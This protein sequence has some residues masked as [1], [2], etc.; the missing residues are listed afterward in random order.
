MRRL[1]AWHYLTNIARCSRHMSLLLRYHHLHAYFPQTKR[2]WKK[3]EWALPR[4]T[5]ILSQL[6]I[7]PDPLL[8]DLSK[9]ESEAL[10][11]STPIMMI[12]W[13]EYWRVRYI[14]HFRCRS[15]LETT[16]LFWR[17]HHEGRRRRSHVH[18]S[19]VIQVQI[20]RSCTCKI[21]V[22]MMSWL[23][24]RIILHSI[25]FRYRRVMATLLLLTFTWKMLSL[26][27][28]FSR[29][30]LSV[31]VINNPGHW[32]PSAL[33][34]RHSS[35]LH[36]FQL[37]THHWHFFS[38]RTVA[39]PTHSIFWLS[40]YADSRICGSFFKQS[41]L[42]LEELSDLVEVPEQQSQ[43]Q[44]KHDDISKQ[45][46]RNKVKHTHPACSTVAII[47]HLIPVISHQHLKNSHT[48]PQNS[49]KIS[50]R[51]VRSIWVIVTALR[52]ETQLTCEEL[53]S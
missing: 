25:Q 6:F 37:F 10:L 9:F 32:D 24:L 16:L 33:K 43:E 41:L 11:R 22:S 5:L 7:L 21:Q 38:S 19:S 2:F 45:H 30:Y 20:L 50:T 35:S 1:L 34:I 12:A 28:C 31:L 36:L 44:I 14:F 47:H 18:T 4:R 51:Q 8:S 53:H 48:R 3:K 40:R 13:S 39:N 23:W 26:G 49:I 27:S 17:A 42:L 29:L 15:G 52:L 46:Q